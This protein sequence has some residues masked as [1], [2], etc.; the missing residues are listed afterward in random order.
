MTR[1]KTVTNFNPDIL[2]RDLQDYLNEGWRIIS[3]YF[4]QGVHIAWIEHNEPD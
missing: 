1:L 4:A 2:E 3:V